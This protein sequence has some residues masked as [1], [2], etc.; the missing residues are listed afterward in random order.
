MSQLQTIRETIA[1]KLSPELQRRMVEVSAQVEN[2]EHG[3]AES[4]GLIEQLAREDSGWMR[5]TAEYDQIFTRAFLNELIK[6]SRVFFLKNPIIR[7]GVLLQSYYV[8]GRGVEIRIDSD[9]DANK[10]LQ[11]FL[12]KN[13]RRLGTIGLTEMEQGIQTD[14]NEFIVSFLAPDNSVLI[15]TIDPLEIVD[16]VTDPQD[17]E[18]PWYYKRQWGE[19]QRSTVDGT[20]SSKPMEAWYRAMDYKPADNATKFAGIPIVENAVMYHRKVGAPAKSLFG[21]PEV[22]AALDWAATYKR[23]LECWLTKEEALSRVAV[24]ISTPGGQQAMDRIKASVQ[25]SRTASTAERNPAPATGSA[26]IGSP[27]QKFETVNTKGSNTSPDEARRALLMAIMLFGPETFFGDA[28]VGSL[29][30]ATSLDRP[31]E[32]KFLHAQTRWSE[33]LEEICGYALRVAK[34]AGITREVMDAKPVKVL[35]SFP[36]IL[37]HDIDKAVGAIVNAATLGGD[38]PAG[39][40]DQRTLSAMLL[41]VLGIKDVS[42]TVDRMYPDGT[43]NAEDWAAMTPEERQGMAADIGARAAAAATQN[44]ESVSAANLASHV[45]RL[46]EAMKDFKRAA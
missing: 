9:D 28:S 38:L 23:F 22:F 6:V 4:L 35:V 42:E 24:K 19:V 8:F 37:E 30:T 26:W 39:T 32:L 18:T 34:G 17:A 31:T 27:G 25:T 14:G 1:N 44:G 20:A 3:L 33:D 46:L 15:R 5:L 41:H 45:G 21:Y 43:Y 16:I 2:L 12:Y 40:I 36:P 13:R 11:D 10:I 7:R 29:A